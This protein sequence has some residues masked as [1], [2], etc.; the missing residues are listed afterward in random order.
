MGYLKSLATSFVWV[1]TFLAIITFIPGLPPNVD[2]TAH[3]LT[4]PKKIPKELL[5]ENLN[6]AEKL[7]QGK[8]R[9][10]ES[11]D[12]YDGILYFTTADGAVHKI[13]GDELKEVV[14]F[15]E[16]C[17]N[18]LEEDLCSHPLGLK[19]DK[20]GTLYVVDTSYGIYKVDVKKGSYEKIIDAS[21]PIEGKLPK[22]PNSVDVAENGDLYWTDM[23]SDYKLNDGIFSTL[24]DPSGRLIHFNAK[25]KKNKVLLDNLGCAN[26]VK[27]SDDESFVLVNEL[28]MSRVVKYHLKGPKTGQSEIIVEGLP[29]FP[30]NIHSDNHGNFLISLVII[31]DEESPHLVQSLLPHPNIRKMCIRFLSLLELP[32]KLFDKVYPNDYCKRI[33]YWIGSFQNSPMVVPTDAI[34]LRIDANGKILNAMA[35]SNSEISSISSA[36]FLN[37]YMWLGSPF[38]DYL[39]RIHIDEILPELKN[40]FDKKPSQK[41]NTQQVKPDSKKESKVKVEL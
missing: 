21:Q 2:F 16:T 5:N 39:A 28:V 24:S 8:V 3:N 10:P 35:I 26:G 32:F 25:T 7:Y 30:D 23:S 13:I 27:L 29:G 31:A 17:K 6:K 36:F 40:K 41:S 19:F 9:G 34:V 37:D 15:K 4:L 20:K 18:K 12:S 11:F 33:H 1:C 38:N 22:T 14:K